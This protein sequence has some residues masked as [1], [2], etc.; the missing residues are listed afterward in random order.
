MYHPPIN[1]RELEEWVE[2]TL[3]SVRPELSPAREERGGGGGGG[4]MNCPIK[5]IIERAVGAILAAAVRY[6]TQTLGNEAMALKQMTL[7]HGPLF[8]LVAMS[9][10]KLQ[11]AARS[12][13][14]S[15][16][17][18]QVQ[19]V[20]DATEHLLLQP[21]MQHSTKGGA[22][23]TSWTMWLHQTNHSESFFSHVIQ[24]VPAADTDTAEDADEAPLEVLANDVG[25]RN[26]RQDRVVLGRV[27]INFHQ[28]LPLWVQAVRD[29]LKLPNLFA[30]ALEAYMLATISEL[31]GANRLACVVRRMRI[32]CTIAATPRVAS[33]FVEASTE[34]EALLA[35]VARRPHKTVDLCSPG[36]EEEATEMDVSLTPPFLFVAPHFFHLSHPILPICHMPFF[37]SG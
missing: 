3:T 21:E 19:Q 1:H 20:R 36:P 29:A 15:L 8:D 16:A 14:V 11:Q 5:K 35:F 18:A 22:L 6:D 28:L 12:G 33:L 31:V 9:C 17:L 7:C 24:V 2:R 23:S 34:I 32:A 13:N 37:C 10:Y 27:R 4:F 25:L 30:V 26:F